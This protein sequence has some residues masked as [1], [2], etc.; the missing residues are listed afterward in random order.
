MTSVDGLVMLV[1]SV[2]LVAAAWFVP[3]Y[4]VRKWQTENWH[5]ICR[6][7]GLIVLSFDDGPSEKLTPRVC[8]LLSELNIRASF[9]FIGERAL[10]HP[11]LVEQVSRSGHDVGGHTARHLNAWKSMPL[12]HCRDL[13]TGQRQIA[14]LVGQTD[15]FR[16]PYGKMS[17]ASLILARM[18][19]LWLAWWTIDPRDS[20]EPRSH[21]D[22]LAQIQRQNG[23]IVLL[24]DYDR[25]PDPG[26]DRYVLDLI[27]KI[28]VLAGENNLQF[29]TLSDLRKIADPSN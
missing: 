5:R 6:D 2:I 29:G 20:L 7:N 11:D 16:P 17:L 14:S 22:V 12:S 15:F 13:L 21:E 8:D 10:R 26:H 24:H 19:K 28:K 1:A 27:R 25:F 3:P 9:F 23:G 18:K 4:V